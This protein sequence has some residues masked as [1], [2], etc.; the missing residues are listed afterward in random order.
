MNLWLIRHGRTEWNDTG[1]Y[2][3]QTDLPL[4]NEGAAE[5]VRADFS[6][7]T[8]YVTPLKRTQE[9]ARILF[10]DARQIVIDDLREMDFGVFEGR[11]YIEMENDD[12]YRAWVEDNCRGRCPGG[13]SREEFA[14]R[15]CAA[16]EKLMDESE[17]DVVIVAHGGTQMSVMERFAVPH[18]P[19]FSRNAKNGTGYELDASNWRSDRTLEHMRRV[20]F[21]KED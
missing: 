19:Y 3:V 21:L 1:R 6:P 11:T 13:E 9:T 5:L 10:P 4:S 12:D 18:E 20:S 15:I 2:Q 16:F 14:A 17:D 8:V 7:K